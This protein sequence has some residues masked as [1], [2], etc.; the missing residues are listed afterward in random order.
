MYLHADVCLPN[1][2]CVVSL[3]LMILKYQNP[4]KLA[5]VCF[6]ACVRVCL[7]RKEV[8]QRDEVTEPSRQPKREKRT[9]VKP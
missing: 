8:R 4:P 2:R 1:A 7:G 5:S 9:L 6:A 3:P